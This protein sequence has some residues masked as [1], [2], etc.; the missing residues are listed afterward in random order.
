MRQ[1]LRCWF[2]CALAFVLIGVAFVMAQLPPMATP[3]LPAPLMYLRF[4]GPK[5][6]KITIYRGFDQGQTLELPCTVGFRPGYVYRFAVTDVP[7]FPRQVFCPSLEVRGTL[8]L[9]PKLRNAEFPAHINFSEDEFFKALNGKHIKKVV[10]LER[11]DLAIPTATKPDEP[12]EIVVPKDRDP[13]VEGA[14]RGQ[15]LV[16][17]QLGQRFLTPQELNAMAIPGTVLLPGE[18]VLGTPRFGPPL[19]WNWYPVHD[20]LHGPR[21]PSEF[22][23]LWDGGDVGV[24]A[25]VTRG[26]KLKGLD[27]TDTIAEYTDSKGNKRIAASNRVGVC[28]PRFIIFKSEAGLGATGTRSAINNNYVMQTPSSAVGQASV[29]EDF[30]LTR[31]DGLGTQMRLSGTFGSMTASVMGRQQGLEV[32]AF[33]RSVESV[34]AIAAG[35]SKAAE[36]ADGPLKIIKWPDKSCVNVGEIVTFYLKYTNTGGQPISDINVNDSLM[37]RFEYVKGST[38][39]DR[40][41][42]FTIQPNDVGSSTLRWEFGAPLQPR[43]SGLI[44]FEVRVR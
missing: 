9:Q 33:L 35:P 16:T 11:P 2:V 44:S 39:T 42:V 29:K 15:P 43:E 24:P 21:H 19:M 6:T 28:V 18:R 41:A 10:T 20:P 38:K 22:H 4:T 14:E 37:Q 7:S 30:R 13:Y 36:P 27:A 5:N 23:T 25:G 8:A 1:P 26:G 17:F 34:D 32:K 3:P 31:T 12:L 40:D